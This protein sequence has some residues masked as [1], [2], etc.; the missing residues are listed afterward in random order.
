MMLAKLDEAKPLSVTSEL[1]NV[2]TGRTATK[3]DQRRTL[4]CHEIGEQKLHDYFQSRVMHQPSSQIAVWT[5]SAFSTLDAPFTIV[6]TALF[7]GDDI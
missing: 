7:A 2:F 3:E 5:Q 6:R 1:S 4:N